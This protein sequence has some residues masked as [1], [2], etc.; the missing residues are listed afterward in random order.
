M[1]WV[2]KSTAGGSLK[3]FRGMGVGRAWRISGDRS[4]PSNLYAWR[5]LPAPWTLPDKYSWE[6]R[7]CKDPTESWK[8]VGDD[9]NDH[10]NGSVQCLPSTWQQQRVALVEI[11]GAKKDKRYWWGFHLSINKLEDHFRDLPIPI[12]KRVGRSINKLLRSFW[13]ISSV[14]LQSFSLQLLH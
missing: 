14:A 12:W 3:N 2:H 13:Q 1:C 8:N 5:S 10:K 7:L 11:R 6:K 9:K 4:P